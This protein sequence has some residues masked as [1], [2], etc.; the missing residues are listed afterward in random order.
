MAKKR[1]AH[2]KRHLRAVPPPAPPTPTFAELVDQ[3]A[4][5]HTALGMLACGRL[6]DQLQDFPEAKQVETADPQKL[7]FAISAWHWKAMAEV[8]QEAEGE[9]QQAEVDLRG[10][11][12]KAS[13]LAMERLVQRAYD[14]LGAPGADDPSLQDVCQDFL[15]EIA[16]EMRS[17][18]W[19]VTADRLDEE[20]R[21]AAAEGGHA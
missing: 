9:A 13:H 6:L 10:D 7:Y 12:L 3:L 15:T 4:Q 17:A 18:L 11:A 5:V 8:A 20:R 19:D 16:A 21:R 2:P 1:A 14:R